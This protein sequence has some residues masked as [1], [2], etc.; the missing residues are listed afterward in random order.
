MFALAA[1]EL[2][3]ANSKDKAAKV[4]TGFVGKLRERLPSPAEFLASFSELQHTGDSS[5]QRLLIKYL[6]ARLDQHGQQNGAVDYDEMSI[7]HIAPQNPKLGEPTAPLN[8]GKIGNLILVPEK[9]N[10]DV[11]GNKAFLKKR[12]IYKNASVPIDDVLGSATT[13]TSVEIDARTNALAVR[14]QEKVFRV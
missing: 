7:E 6:L 10:N 3:E 11:L 9:L 8:V 13:W 12:E 1:R 14:V 5:K 4:L 2:E